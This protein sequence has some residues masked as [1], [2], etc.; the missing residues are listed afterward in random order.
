MQSRLLCI[1][2]CVALCAAAGG[3][4]AQP[5]LGLAPPGS[6]PPPRPEPPVARQFDLDPAK[7]PHRALLYA[8]DYPF[9]DQIEGNAALGY[10]QVLSGIGRLTQEEIESLDA[11]LHDPPGQFKADRAQQLFDSSIGG[12]WES[13]VLAARHDHC[14]W[15]TPIRQ[16]GI[17]TLLPELGKLRIMGRLIAVRARL[18]IIAGQFDDALAT[19][20]IGFR[21]A[22]DVGKGAT[23]IQ[24]LVGKAIGGLMLDQIE[25][26]SRQKGAPS[27]YWA[28]TDLPIPFVNLG[29]AMRNEAAF[30]DVT[31]PDFKEPLTEQVD[32][33]TAETLVRNH[34]A[35]LDRLMN[36]FGVAR[37][38]PLASALASASQTASRFHP[39]RQAMLDAGFSPSEV[40]ALPVTFVTL[41]HSVR[42]YRAAHDDITKWINV[43]YWQAAPRIH[44][45][46]QAFDQTVSRVLGEPFSSLMSSIGRPFMTQALIDRR[47]AALRI[48]EAIRLYAAS[49]RRLPASLAEIT[50]WPIP[51]DPTTGGAF[52]YR[53][54]GSAAVLTSPP[55]PFSNPNDSGSTIEYHITLRSPPPA[56]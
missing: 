16:T 21:L 40:D 7:P 9:A 11:L 43:P 29:P 8:F 12:T 33:Y 41:W 47:V 38:N 10:Y 49:T 2:M 45:A 37:P 28:L 44:L 24:A 22:F 27:L 51:V 15:E 30:F 4:Q 26:L 19:L 34:R 3:A 39:A 36:E 18:Q 35:R 54:E 25:L 23:L 56:R 52:T 42:M 50:D 48:V 5:A 55:P 14:S 13:L 53:L 20:R 6:F 46:E 31:F 17:G 32:P 1:P